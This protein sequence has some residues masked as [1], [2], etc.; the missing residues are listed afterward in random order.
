MFRSPPTPQRFL[1][2]AKL[3]LL[4][5]IELYCED[6]VGDAGTLPVLQFITSHVLPDDSLP[7][8]PSDKAD[9]IIDIVSSIKL[10]ERALRPFPAGGMPGRTVW[11][12]FVERIWTIDSLH[13]LHSFLNARAALIEPSKEDLRRGYQDMLPAESAINMRLGAGS[14]FAVFV[15]KAAF[16]YTRLRFQDMCALWKQFVI[17][18]QPTAGYMRRRHNSFNRLSFD[19]VLLTSEPEWGGENTMRVAEAVYQDMITG[20]KTVSSPVTTDDL[21]RL[22]DFQIDQMQKFGTRVPKRIEKKFR[23]FLDEAVTVP[24][25]RHYLRCVASRGTNK[26]DANWAVSWTPGDGATTRQP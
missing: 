5:L 23:Q 15:S 24:T 25:F 12:V 16:E 6:A 13:V 2:P 3:C 11:D 26:T 20:L 18:R 4:A 1:N 21:E 7:D 17:Y 9:E 8:G 14:P 22:L 10:F 19:S